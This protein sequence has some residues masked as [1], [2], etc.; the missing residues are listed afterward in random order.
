M[1]ITSK[2][3]GLLFANLTCLG[4]QTKQFL[5]TKY[6]SHNSHLQSAL[7]QLPLIWTQVQVLTGP[8]AGALP[9]FVRQSEWRQALSL[10]MV[11]NNSHFRLVFKFR[12][13]LLFRKDRLLVDRTHVYQITFYNR[14]TNWCF[15]IVITSCTN[16]LFI[17]LYFVSGLCAQAIWSIELR[18]K[19]LR[20]SSAVCQVPLHTS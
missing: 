5:L 2:F 11:L 4:W 7:L 14:A 16:A 20:N 10:S 17:R 6:K 19:G 3:P 15:S 18:W 9:V 12:P 8:T 13:S 1:N